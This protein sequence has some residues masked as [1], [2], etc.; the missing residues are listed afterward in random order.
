M[1]LAALLT[2]YAEIIGDAIVN[3]YDWPE[4]GV[5]EIDRVLRYHGH[6][7][8]EDME[9]G[10]VLAVWWEPP[11]L[12]VETTNCA[13]PL[14]V[15]LAAKYLTCWKI[16]KVKAGPGGSQIQQWDDS[17]DAT[18]GTLA[19]VAETVARRLVRLQCHERGD[20]IDEFGEAML[21]LI[22]R[23]RFVGATPTGAA[24][25]AAGVIWRMTGQLAPQP[26]AAAAP[27]SFARTADDTIGVDS[28]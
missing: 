23:P 4:S 5:H 2:A 18:A 8:P 9:C 7:P 15:T 3:D 16:A 27:Q 21:A 11:S 26:A 19:D 12:T 25:G 17:W 1:T 28:A 20:P 6:A 10:E 24:G 13:G 14:T 22:V